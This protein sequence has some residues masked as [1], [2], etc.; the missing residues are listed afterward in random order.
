MV[1][2]ADVDF[3]PVDLDDTPEGEP[4]SW[5]SPR[6]RPPNVRSSAAYKVMREQFTRFH[7]NHR[8]PDGTIGSPCAITRCGRPINYALAYPHPESASVDHI[9]PIK[10]HPHLALE[11]NN[12]QP[13]HLICNLRK[14]GEVGDFDLDIGEPSEQW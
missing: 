14:N 3:S 6:P 4:V 7:R 8:N 2:M 11:W 9:L 13:A 12:C 5:S 10:T 1:I